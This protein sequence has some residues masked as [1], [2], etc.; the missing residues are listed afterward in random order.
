VF[1]LSKTHFR[2][3]V[4]FDGVGIRWAYSEIFCYFCPDGFKSSDQNVLMLQRF[5]AFLI[6]AADFHRKYKVPIDVGPQPQI[7]LID[8][9]V[10]KIMESES[11]LGFRVLKG[12]VSRRDSIMK[13]YSSHVDGERALQKQLEVSKI[14]GRESHAKLTKGCAPGLCA[15]IED[16]IPG[17]PKFTNK[18]LVTLSTKVKTL[19][20]A[21]WVHGDL[22]LCN[23]IFL[24]DDAVDLIDFDWS[25][26]CGE[27][28]FP[29]NARAESFGSKA[30]QRIR[31]SIHIPREFDWVC[32]SDIFWSLGCVDA[33]RYAENRDFEHVVQ[34]LITKQEWTYPIEHPSCL[35]LGCLEIHYYSRPMEPAEPCGERLKCRDP[36]LPSRLGKEGSALTVRRPAGCPRVDAMA[37]E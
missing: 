19:Y 35:D 37:R 12:Y 8:S 31:P 3:G 18:H 30:C 36:R 32:L 27:A 13:F 26:Q 15:I 22:R 33:A 11:T 17:V 9:S 5:F 1:V 16:Y 21:G 24:P 29:A 25:G 2:I 20:D 28:T 34:S 23:M 7:S 10:L 14:L 4:A 6:Q